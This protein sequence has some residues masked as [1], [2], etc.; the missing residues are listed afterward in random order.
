MQESVMWQAIL[1]RERQYDG[2]FVFAV[3]TT[4]VYCRPTCPARRPRRENVHFFDQPAEAEAAG[5]RPCQRCH[6]A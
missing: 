6:P 2:Q 5:Y 4:G 1:N 3:R